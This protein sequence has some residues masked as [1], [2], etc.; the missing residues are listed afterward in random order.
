MSG[1]A[2]FK[3]TDPAEELPLIPA[4]TDVRVLLPADANGKFAVLV[5]KLVGAG[6]QLRQVRY[7][8]EDE[9]V[10]ASPTYQE[11]TSRICRLHRPYRAT[12]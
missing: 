2:W 4:D 3:V 12:A 6:A 10:T 1:I 11:A 5:D 7:L 8:L 9:V